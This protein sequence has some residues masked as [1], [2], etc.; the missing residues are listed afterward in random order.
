[1]SS[2]K[3]R[4]QAA[5]GNKINLYA[6]GNALGYDVSLNTSSVNFGEVHIGKRTQ[7]VVNVENR[8]NLATKFQFD[9]DSSS[10]FSFSESSGNLPARS[11]VRIVITFEPPYTNI[12]YQRVFCLIRNH[13]VCPLDLIGTCYDILTKPLPLMQRHIEVYRHKVIHNLALDGQE[14]MNEEEKLNIEIP[15]DDPT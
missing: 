13:Q 1:M 10:I 11:S 9:C 12:F 2:A 4:L 14:A 8:S 6:S 3:F 7:R 5:S 15:I